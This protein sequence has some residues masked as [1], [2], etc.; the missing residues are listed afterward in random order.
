MALLDKPIEQPW[1]VEMRPGFKGD[2]SGLYFAYFVTEAEAIKHKARLQR[3]GKHNG[4]VSYRPGE[5]WY[6]GT[7]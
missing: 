7:I 6:A 4:P 2:A 3:R 1:A 5:S